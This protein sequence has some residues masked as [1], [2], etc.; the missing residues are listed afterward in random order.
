[1]TPYAKKL[2]KKYKIDLANVMGTSP[3]G[4]IT[5]SDIEATGRRD[6][7]ATFSFSI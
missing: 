5:P 3:N 2:A 4:R 7:F 6:P 1:V